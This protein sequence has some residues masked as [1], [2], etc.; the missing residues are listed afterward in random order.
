VE[1]LKIIIKRGFITSGII[2]L[3]GILLQ[4]KI[5]YMG[6]FGGS[7]LSILGFYM[8][9]LDAK[10]SLHSNSPFKVSVIGYIKR[11][12]LYGIYLG[13]MAKFFG[14]PM[15]IAGALG[16]LSIKFN[17]WL[18]FGVKNIKSLKSKYLP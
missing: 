10:T 8:I 11:Y 16:L 14:M 15:I 2:F 5:I 17:I 9:S 3:Y 12:I 13:I 1:L 18:Y 4:N 7:L 6:M